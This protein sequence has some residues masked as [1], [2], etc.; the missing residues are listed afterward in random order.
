[1]KKMRKNKST[2]VDEVIRVNHAGEFGAKRIYEGQLKF[3]KDQKAL[4]LVKDM[5]RQ[6][7]EHLNYFD[8]EIVDRDVR[9]TVLMPIW[10]KLGFALGAVTAMIGKEAA[11]ACTVAVEEV[12]EEHYQEQIDELQKNH[13]KEIVLF[14]KIKQFQ[15]EEVEHKNI[16]MENNA[17]ESPAFKVLTTCIKKAS[18]LAIW[19]S[20]RI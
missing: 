8:N 19:L 13:P 3:L 9:P 1:M 7:L 15:Q 10:N 20:K 5:Y 17:M 11:M 4:E 2:F 14:D 6:E 16:G 12:I 18:K